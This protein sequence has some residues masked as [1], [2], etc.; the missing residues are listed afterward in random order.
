M[1]IYVKMSAAAG[2]RSGAKK[3]FC[4]FVIKSKWNVPFREHCNVKLSDVVK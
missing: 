4:L 1:E 3:M 2:R